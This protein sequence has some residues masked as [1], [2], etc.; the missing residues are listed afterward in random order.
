[1][2]KKTLRTR[3]DPP[4]IASF[5][6]IMEPVIFAIARMSP[7]RHQIWPVKEKVRIAAKFVAM[8]TSFAVADAL[9]NAYPTTPTKIKSKKE[10][11]PGPKIPS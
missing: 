2:I 11:V 8:F 6:P 1:M 5:A 9:R 10:P 4:L 3:G 7:T